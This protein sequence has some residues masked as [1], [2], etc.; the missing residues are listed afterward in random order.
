MRSAI[1]YKKLFSSNT[2]SGLL[3]QQE[4]GELDILERME[5]M[6]L[7]ESTLVEMGEDAVGLKPFFMNTSN[8]M[9]YQ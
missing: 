1:T 2:T 5:K 3:L 7:L 6:K 4:L 9:K 8:Y